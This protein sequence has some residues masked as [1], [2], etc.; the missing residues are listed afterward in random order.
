[1]TIVKITGG[2]GNQLF[3]YA[4]GKY[5]EKKFDIDVKYHVEVDIIRK[6]FTR[7]DLD[8]EK[9]NI[10]LHRASEN[11]IYN[12]LKFKNGLLRRGDRKLSQFFPFL[13]PN[14]IIQKNA[15]I[16]LLALQNKGYYDGYWQCCHYVDEVRDVLLK[17]IK[18]APDF[19]IKHKELLEEINS[20]FSVAIHV[21]RDDY[22]NV[23]ANA[24]LYA[25]CE[26]EYY[27]AAIKILEKEVARPH[28]YIFSQDKE[29]VK[30]NF[31][32]D[33]FHFV[34]DNTAIDDMLLMA[35]CSHN[36]IAN[37]TFSWWG[38]WF[39]TNPNKIVIAPKKWY[40]GTINLD[41]KNL[42]PKN[43]LRI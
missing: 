6:N 11:E 20:T 38:A 30:Q 18:P 40:R 13:R 8:L 9:F 28:F 22:I 26:K 12:Y 43:W 19:Y 3:Q 16:L 39:N 35:H 31:T 17:Q 23:K 41:T 5:L 10:E 42:I 36:I 32:G 25:I 29:W 33:H 4:F 37:S 7:R 1:M 27:Q 24:K 21:R 2:L 14:Y 34:S 15:H